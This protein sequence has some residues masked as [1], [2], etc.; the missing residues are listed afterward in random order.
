MSTLFSGEPVTRR[1]LSL[2]VAFTLVLAIVLGG[3]AG[4]FVS[5]AREEF[6]IGGEGSEGEEVGAQGALEEDTVV[7]VVRRAAPAVA[8]IVISVEQPVFE[9]S[10]ER[11]S[12][13]GSPFF[14][15]IPRLRELGT[16]RQVVGAGTG[17]FVSADGYLVTNRHVVENVDA[18]YT[19]IT[20]D[21]T[22]YAATVLDRDPV[23]DLAVLRVEGSAFPTL[24]LGDSDAIQIGERAIAIGYALGRFTNT[25]SVGVVSGLGRDIR[26]TSGLGQLEALEDLIQTDAAIN[27]GNSGG[28]LLDTHG[29]VIGVNV[30]MAQ[31]SQN[32]GFAIPANVARPVIE[33]VR[34]H[35]RIVRPQ[36]GI[37]YTVITPEFAEEE[38]LPVEYGALIVGGG[39]SPAGVLSGSPA[40]AA[41]LREG[42]IILELDGVRL[43]EDHTLASLIGA[44]QVGDTITLRVRRGEEEFTVSV[45]LKEWQR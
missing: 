33:S 44:R 23:N 4:L 22:E 12:P 15:E 29:L 25:V 2:T 43:D 27:P 10:I 40:E 21:G 13:F 39:D 1:T 42:D 37:R 19:V 38:G 26:A 17:F 5:S 6:P 9:R 16:E 14:F 35:G 30:A 20:A 7:A 28:P 36:L 45:T 32:I 31:G 24:E 11:F 18:T 41:G 34:E 3:A 8:S